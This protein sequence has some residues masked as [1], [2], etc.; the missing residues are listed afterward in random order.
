[1]KEMLAFVRNP[2]P[3]S[4]SSAAPAQAVQRKR[5]LESDSTDESGAKRNTRQQGQG[6]NGGLAK[7]MCRDYHS[8]FS[9]ISA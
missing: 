6:P 1:V 5:P 8:K 2:Q 3:S 9:L 7:G 4:N